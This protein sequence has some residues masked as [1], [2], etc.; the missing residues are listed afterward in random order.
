MTMTLTY[1]Q[2]GDWGEPGPFPYNAVDYIFW[3]DL[4]YTSL[5]ILLAEEK[6][7]RIIFQAIR[8]RKSV[9]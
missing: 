7:T 1:E 2:Q 3:A 8:S 5:L 6:G 4:C 9:F